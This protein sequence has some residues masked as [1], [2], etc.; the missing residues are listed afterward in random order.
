MKRQSLYNILVKFIIPKIGRLVKRGLHGTESKVR[1][2]NYLSSN[3]HIENGLKP[4][5]AL[6]QL[7][8]NFVLEYA[9]WKVQETNL[10]W[11]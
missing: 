11:I 4:G 5:N 7:L 2:G 8:Y 10:D 9:I 1:I 6:S 3:F